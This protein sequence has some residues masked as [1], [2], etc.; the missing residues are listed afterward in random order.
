MPLLVPSRQSETSLLP[1]ALQAWL[2]CDIVA[3]G[4]PCLPPAMHAMHGAELEKAMVLQVRWHRCGDASANR[5]RGTRSCV[6]ARRCRQVE[7]VRNV[8]AI[9]EDQGK[10]PAT[11]S[12]TLLFTL[13]DGT[14][15]VQ[16]LE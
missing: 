8:A 7:A 1:P 10:I 16:A 9:V 4:S 2:Q 14:Q 11:G 3:A 12:R 13:T 6:V 5:S 15:A